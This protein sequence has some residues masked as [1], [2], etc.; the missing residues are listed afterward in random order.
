[1][2][3]IFYIVLVVL[4]LLAVLSGTSKILLMSQDVEFFGKYGF[5]DFALIV[6][7]LVQLVGG[8]LIAIPKTR[9]V[10]AL[11]VATTFLVSAVLLVLSGNIPIGLV[12]LLFVGLLGFVVKYN[13]RISFAADKNVERNS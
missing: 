1:M 4:V 3:I 10:G 2:K 12:T 9:S 8:I 5:S 13:S 6:F 11:L 7:G